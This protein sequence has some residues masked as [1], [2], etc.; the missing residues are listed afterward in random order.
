M[1]SPPPDPRS[2]ARSPLGFDEFIGV[3]VALT[4]IGAIL[5]WSLSRPNQGFNLTRLLAPSPSPSP[6][7]PTR[8]STTPEATTDA[9]PELLPAPTVFPTES[10]GLLPVPE[11]NPVGRQFPLVVP[12]RT[13][14]APTQTV[15][16]TEGQPINFVDVPQN[17]WARPFIDALSARGIVTGFAGDYFRPDRPVTRAEFAALLQDAFDQNPGQNTTQ[18]KDVP[19]DFWAVPAINRANQTGFL[20]GYPGNIFRPQQEIP[21]AQVLVA[22]ASGL[23]LPTV[24]APEQVLGV[25]KDANQIPDYAT[26]RVAAA[27]QAGLVTNYPDPKLLQPNRNASR[28]EV[29]AIIHQALAQAGKVEP[30][31]SQYAVPGR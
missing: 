14:P 10:P 3:F 23:N 31:E 12:Y 21:R 19:A 24:S 30:I 4:T 15:R 29:A 27:T 11:R 25:Y 1:T 20:E 7:E 16:P 2:S 22:L 13:T 17:Y 8:T 26:E 28:A 9:S 6:T 18:F 5:F